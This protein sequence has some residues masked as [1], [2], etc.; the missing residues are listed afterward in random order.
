MGAR[1]TALKQEG[2]E[3]DQRKEQG[4]AEGAAVGSGEGHK[5]GGGTQVVSRGSDQGENLGC[6]PSA[7]NPLLR[8]A[9]R[10]LPGT[11]RHTTPQRSCTLH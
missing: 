5:W 8:V 1:H 10:S 2:K 7:S 3:R 4:M 6:S 11:V 9:T